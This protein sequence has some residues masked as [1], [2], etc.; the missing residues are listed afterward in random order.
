MSTI[1]PES[2]SLSRKAQKRVDAVVAAASSQLSLRTNNFYSCCTI[3]GEYIHP[4][5]VVRQT[6]PRYSS[7]VRRTL[8]QRR[9]GSRRPTLMVEVDDLRGRLLCCGRV[10]SCAVALR[11]ARSLRSLALNGLGWGIMS[12]FTTA[13]RGN[14]VRG[15]H[16]R[17]NPRR[18]R[19][20]HRIC[21]RWKLRVG[22]GGL[23]KIH[24]VR[25]YYIRAAYI[26]LI[27][28]LASTHSQPRKP[29][30]FHAACRD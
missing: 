16:S 12:A 29:E 22:E 2:S 23:L 21:S 27:A 15:V 9:Y 25:V 5:Y 8:I 18:P 3:A 30:V 7:W 10:R 17:N 19:H 4:G 26:P 11:Q 13:S 28:G 24:E 14:R 1:P 6:I 20:L